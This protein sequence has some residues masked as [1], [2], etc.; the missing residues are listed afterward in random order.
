MK[1][2]TYTVRTFIEMV[3][4]FFPCFEKSNIHDNYFKRL[5]KFSKRSLLKYVFSLY[6]F[7]GYESFCL[8]CKN[9]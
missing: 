2:E 9:G 7:V 8:V 3:L 6:L 5:P 4:T 1:L